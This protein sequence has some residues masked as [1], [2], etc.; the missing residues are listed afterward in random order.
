MSQQSSAEY[1]LPFRLARQNQVLE[2]RMPIDKMARLGECLHSDQASAAYRLHFRKNE[3][4][5]Y[6]ATGE[7]SSTV[8]MV[9]QRCMQPVTTDVL[10]TV[11]VAFVTSDAQAEKVSEEYEPLMVSDDQVVLSEFI[12]DELILAL[13][14]VAT[15]ADLDCQSWFKD[16]P[17][18]E[19][20]EEPRKNPFAE[21]A[22]LKKP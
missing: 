20:K 9:C 1:I 12:E 21:L 19:F 8:E 14:I 18:P 6:I 10:T 16:N 7:I 2:G 5:R 4:G 17:E 15:H 13:P 22:K 3:G 11:S